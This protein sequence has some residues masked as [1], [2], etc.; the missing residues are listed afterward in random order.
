MLNIKFKKKKIL[1]YQNIIRVKHLHN[2]LRSLAESG[3][4][5]HKFK[6][7]YNSVMSKKVNKKEKP[8]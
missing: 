4:R 8:T 5:K 7:N 3:K 6:Y 2:Q 1:R